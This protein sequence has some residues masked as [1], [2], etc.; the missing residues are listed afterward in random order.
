M[1][2]AAEALQDANCALC[3]GNA[4]AKAASVGGP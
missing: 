4:A 3:G 1:M 2:R